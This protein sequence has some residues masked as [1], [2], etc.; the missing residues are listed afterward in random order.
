MVS[1]SFN[2]C[3]YRSLEE[4]QE[5]LVTQLG[6]ACSTENFP[7]CRGQ[8]V[9]RSIRH[10]SRAYCQLAGYMLP[11]TKPTWNQTTPL[12]CRYSKNP[13]VATWV[14]K[15]GPNWDGRH[16]NHHKF[17]WKVCL[18]EAIPK[19][20]ISLT[21]G[22]KPMFNLYMHNVI[23]ISEA[24]STTR[25]FWLSHGKAGRQC[26]CKGK[27]SWTNLSQGAGCCYPRRLSKTRVTMNTSGWMIRMILKKESYNC[28]SLNSYT[29]L[30]EKNTSRWF[31]QQKWDRGI[32]DIERSDG[33]LTE[34]WR[35]LPVTTLGA[36]IC[37]NCLLSW[38]RF[39]WPAE[40]MILL[41]I[42]HGYHLVDW[43]IAMENIHFSW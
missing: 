22:L 19:P 32:V 21:S 34:N 39:C 43:Q 3:N 16:Q 38:C 14:S 23:F 29:P 40:L 24:H 26:N 17:C 42:S 13:E 9:V 4:L 33:F 8:K 25:W 27:I 12:T 7:G 30:F 1:I 15:L 36:W 2:W 18:S 11:T 35:H 41:G 37:Y 10:S 6:T 28:Q 31:S 20:V 5:V